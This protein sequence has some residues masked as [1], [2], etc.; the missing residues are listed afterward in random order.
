MFVP[1]SENIRDVSKRHHNITKN[2]IE[3]RKT[4]YVLEANGVTLLFDSEKSACEFL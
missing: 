1:A 4:K 2:A 3:S